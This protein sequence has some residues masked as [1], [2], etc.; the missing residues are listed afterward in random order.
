MID[1]LKKQEDKFKQEAEHIKIEA[2]I[3]KEENEA[4]K[5]ALEKKIEKVLNVERDLK[6]ASQR[7][8]NLEKE[9]L[10]LKQT[11]NDAALTP[12]KTD[13]HNTSIQS[14]K[15]KFK[16]NSANPNS[17][18]KTT[19]DSMHMFYSRNVTVPSNCGNDELIIPMSSNRS[20]HKFTVNSGVTKNIVMKK[21]AK[22]PYIQA[23]LEKLKQYINI[24]KQGGHKRSKSQTIKANQNT[25]KAV[26]SA[27]RAD[28]LHTEE[29]ADDSFYGFAKECGL[30][31]DY[32]SIQNSIMYGGG[33]KNSAHSKSKAKPKLSKKKIIKNQHFKSYDVRSSLN[34]YELV[35]PH[36]LMDT[37]LDKGLNKSKKKMKAKRNSS[38]SKMPNPKHIQPG[39]K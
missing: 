27:L 29:T 30:I 5:K 17:G 26:R 3:I 22:S 1:K 18:R 14:V 10:A 35:N 23:D 34:K 32:N 8:H 28:H 21:D 19:S 6:E 39:V 25:R 16:S 20:P 9:L 36:G 11:I 12:R 7:Y 33:Q 38:I 15:A 37:S 13:I 31:K 4:L 2:K 24:P